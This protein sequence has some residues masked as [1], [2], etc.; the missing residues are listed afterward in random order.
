[1][2]TLVSNLRDFS[3]SGGHFN[4]VQGNQMNYYYSSRAGAQDG[5]KVDAEYVRVPTGK[6]L[7]IEKITSG[8]MNSSEHNTSE[9]EE[10][11]ELNAQRS[12]YIA[13]IHGDNDD[14]RFLYVSYQGPDAPRAYEREFLRYSR[15]KHVDQLFFRLF[16]Y[17]DS[18]L[19]ALIFYDALIPLSRVFEFH[20]CSPI[21]VW[22]LLWQVRSLDVDGYYSRP[23]RAAD[24]YNE[25]WV[26]PRTGNLC[27]GPR[28]PLLTNGVDNADIE[29]RFLD[30]DPHL[31]TPRSVEHP[32][33]PLNRYDD[34]SIS[35]YLRECN[36]DDET[37]LKCLFRGGDK[38]QLS[39]VNEA[40]YWQN[41]LSV[42]AP[43]ISLERQEVVSRCLGIQYRPESEGCLVSFYNLRLEWL[44]QTTLEY[45]C[46]LCVPDIMTQQDTPNLTAWVQG[47]YYLS[48]DPFGE[49]PIPEECHA[50]MGLPI[51][52][53]VINIYTGYWYK[54]E[55]Q[56]AQRWQE[57]NGFD[58]ETTDFARSLGY[59]MWEIVEDNYRF[60]DVDDWEMDDDG[61]RSGDERDM[62]VD[63][64]LESQSEDMD[65]D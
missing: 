40:E 28:G 50:A 53:P 35:R 54:F 7:I 36:F 64:E 59:P 58:P 1:M 42:G 41:T 37:L 48:F 25:L 19:P 30:W 22:H 38:I 60:E 20:Q 51:L 34:Q 2:A 57:C 3:A 32:A 4:N 45:P 65:V 13:K 8:R 43:I 12:I 14:A 11:S 56:F 10:S 63:A 33:L 26:H 23:S 44:A 21:L 17:N 9:V 16:G 5:K 52:E 29:E 31:Q 18:K 47:S 27:K 46:Y 39:H 49:T 55:Y 62:N 61:G 24:F 6:V 15:S